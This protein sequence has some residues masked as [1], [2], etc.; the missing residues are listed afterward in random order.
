MTEQEL[1]NTSLLNTPQKTGI[2]MRKVAEPS[3]AT[4]TEPNLETREKNAEKALNSAI[5][6]QLDVKFNKLAQT[7]KYL[8]FSAGSISAGENKEY[9]TIVRHSDG[10]E[11][12]AMVARWSET[13]FEI[14]KMYDN[15]DGKTF[16]YDLTTKEV[17]GKNRYI[18]ANPPYE[19][20]GKITNSSIKFE[21]ADLADRIDYKKKFG[22]GR[23][24]PVFT[25]EVP[26]KVTTK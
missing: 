11:E 22:P 3:K 8:P 17:G 20:V 18:T 16:F 7:F 1:K 15:P 12:K 26:V 2:N 14:A 19:H 6:E 10:R 5:D 13:K 24:I 4:S 21:I 23:E 25:G 9:I